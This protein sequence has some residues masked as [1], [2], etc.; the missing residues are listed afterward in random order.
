MLLPALRGPSAVGGLSDTDSEGCSTK[1]LR[2]DAKRRREV[3]VHSQPGIASV[4]APGPSAANSLSDLGEEDDSD[5]GEEACGVGR[6][7]P[8]QTSTLKSI[9]DTCHRSLASTCG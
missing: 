3:S 1:R 2:A 7:L 6:A 5:P 4:P 8:N 9:E